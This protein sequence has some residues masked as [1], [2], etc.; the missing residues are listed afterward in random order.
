M[1]RLLLESNTRRFQFSQGAFVS[2]VAHS[3]L[4]S[5]SILATRDG[6]AAAVEDTTEKVTFLVP[7]NH[8]TSP[9]PR[10]ESVQFLR[11]GE[12]AGSGGFEQKVIDK[13]ATRQA[14]V[15]GKGTEE[16]KPEEVANVIA[17]LACDEASYVTGAVWAADGGMTAI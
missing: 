11:E 17:F 5:A 13:E 15:V 7:L 8:T 2:L 12:K 4:I 9:P 3:L 10:E 1:L 6:P 16:G 14:P